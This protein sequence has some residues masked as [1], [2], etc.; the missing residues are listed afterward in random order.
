MAIRERDVGAGSTRFDVRVDGGRTQ[1]EPIGD[2]LKRFGQDAATLVRQEITLVKLELR[3][4]AKGLAKDA[5]KLG[6]AAGL[7]LFGGLALLA[8]LIV[9]LGDLIDN[10]WLSALIVSVLLLGAAALMARG[11]LRHVQQSSMAP[12]E[13]VQT[14][15]DDQRWAKREVQDFKQSMKA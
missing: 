10:Y 9:G 5:G 11:A 7:A 3:E 15:K 13:T 4:S 1:E 6:A 14:L 8:F 2:L 12:R